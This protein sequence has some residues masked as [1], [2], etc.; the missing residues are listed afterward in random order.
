ML[1]K[2]RRPPFQ[3]FSLRLFTLRTFGD[4]GGLSDPV[5]GPFCTFASLFTLVRIPL[6]SLDRGTV[7][8]SS[9]F[10]FLTMEEFCALPRGE[11]I[12]YID[13]A[14]AEIQGMKGDVPE[15]VIFKD[16]PL[17]PRRKPRSRQL[18]A[19][20]ALTFLTTEAF[21]NLPQKEKFKYLALAI[22]QLKLLTDTLREQEGLL[23]LQ[24]DPTQ[25]H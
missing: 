6:T 21:L 13:E 17:P 4:L 10:Q 11:K 20:K 19:T 12:G 7:P 8:Q 14:M 1:K 25:R 22:E 24:P 15:H 18:P 9:K 3:S 16:S 2:L 23:D 5:N